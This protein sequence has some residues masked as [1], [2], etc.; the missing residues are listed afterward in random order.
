M[1]AIECC[2]ERIR[3]V[4]ETSRTAGLSAPDEFD[5]HKVQHALDALYEMGYEA[6]KYDYEDRLELITMQCDGC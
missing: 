2:V 1:K 6:T 3:A 4:L 5:K